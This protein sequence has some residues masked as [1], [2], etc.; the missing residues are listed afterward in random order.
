MPKVNLR[1]RYLYAGM[2]LGP[3]EDIDV[4]PEQHAWLRDQTNNFAGIPQPKAPAT[5][6]KPAADAGESETSVSGRKAIDNVGLDPAVAEKL[7]EAGYSTVAAVRKASDEE[8]DAI[9]GIGPS[10]VAKIR[11]ATG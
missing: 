2:P 4:T 11:A 6:S 3:G 9:E 8:L 10:T 5:A 1:E 7:I